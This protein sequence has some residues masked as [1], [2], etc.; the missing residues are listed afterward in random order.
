MRAPHAETANLGRDRLADQPLCKGCLLART[1]RDETR[2]R[3]DRTFTHR[4][5]SP[6]YLRDR[7][8]CRVWATGRGLSSPPGPTGA[9]ARSDR[10][11]CPSRTRS[12]P[13][14]EAVRDSMGPPA[15]WHQCQLV[16]DPLLV[17]DEPPV[18]IS[19]EFRNSSLINAPGR[20]AWCSGA[21]QPCS[22]KRLWPTAPA[23]IGKNG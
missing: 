18:E 21:I 8:P 23:S 19:R 16:Q 4:E 6:E 12:R 5:F 1:P 3:P 10:S 22:V 11:R 7:R 2:V 15:L 13:A 14:S 20:T 17:L 9:G